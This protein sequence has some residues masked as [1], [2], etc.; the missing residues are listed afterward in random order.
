[1]MFLHPYPVALRLLAQFP[2]FKAAEVVLVVD[3]EAQGQERVLVGHEE[4]GQ[5]AKLQHGRVDET[6]AGQRQANGQK[7]VILPVC[8]CVS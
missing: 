8:R 5:L 7:Q 6:C 2:A 3:V 4:Q 1:M